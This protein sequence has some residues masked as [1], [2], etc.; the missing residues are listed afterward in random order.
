ML[1]ASSVAAQSVRPGTRAPEIDLPTLDGGRVQLSRLRGRPVIVSFWATWCSPCRAEFPEL[2]RVHDAA[3]PGGIHVIGVNSRD[4]ENRTSDVQKFVD[5]YAAAFAIALD[6][7][8][9]AR[10]AYGLMGLPTT[11][12]IDSAGVVRLVHIGPIDRNQL[13]KAILT[14]Q[15]RR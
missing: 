8:G 4:Q 9:R 10:K 5:Q 11:V 7:R 12:F 15:T 3:G 13:A 2:V 1:A 6:Q 14:I